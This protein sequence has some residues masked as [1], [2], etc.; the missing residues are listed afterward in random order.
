M[1]GMGTYTY[2]NQNQTSVVRDLTL[3]SAT[4]ASG[5]RTQ[6]D[7]SS[8]TST[9]SEGQPS[10]GGSSTTNTYPETLN[11]PVPA[12]G[13]PVEAAVALARGGAVPVLGRVMAAPSSVADGRFAVGR[14]TGAIGEMLGLGGGM[15]GSRATR[16]RSSAATRSMA[17]PR[18]C[19]R[20]PTRAPSW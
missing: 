19:S 13:N 12:P 8:W 14:I 4:S 11:N 9:P 2:S 7:S 6:V 18:I 1:L 20:R 16:R 3:A 15:G 10:S 17:L 5:T